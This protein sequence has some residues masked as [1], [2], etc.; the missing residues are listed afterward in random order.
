MRER[1][2]AGIS[3]SFFFFFFQL[4]W[5]TIRQVQSSTEF[6]RINPL[7]G[8]GDW[9]SSPPNQTFWLVLR[10]KKNPASKCYKNTA[11]RLLP[12]QSRSV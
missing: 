2:G 3:N 11:A 10:Q 6:S 9:G 12:S 7:S 8:P 5:Y 1:S 4:S